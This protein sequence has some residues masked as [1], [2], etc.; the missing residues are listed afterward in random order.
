MVSAHHRHQEIV[1]LL[2]QAGRVGVG[3]LTEHFQVTSETIRRD[4]RSLEERGMVERVHGGA[5]LPGDNNTRP[6]V[7]HFTPT[8]T[9]SALA[10]T[11]SQLIPT[12]TRSIFLDAGPAGTA[13]AVVL[14]SIYEE[15]NW[16][17]VTTSPEAG[18]ILARA[19]MP[20]IGM[21]GGRLSVRSQSLTGPRAVEM[22]TALRADIA[23]I[24]PD[25]IIEQQSLTSIDPNAG[26]TRRAMLT[27]AAF[28][29][30]LT[31]AE[32]FSQHRGTVFGDLAE[33]DVLVT[34]SAADDPP[35]IFLSTPDLQVVTP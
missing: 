15:H 19:G 31:P 17:V 11:A 23:F 21:V 5:I 18:I 4:L 29:V 6:G 1:A 12:G 24:C 14:A 35:L 32:C 20:R 13:L 10:R 27:H 33:I 3:M 7:S 8:P 26:V 9:M 25:G 16:T 22:I 28:T 30:S 34:D 2:S